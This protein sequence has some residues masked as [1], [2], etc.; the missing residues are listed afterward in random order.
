MNFLFWN[1]NKNKNC[2]SIIRDMIYTEDIDILMIAE[3]PLYTSEDELLANF[4]TILK[5]YT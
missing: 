5:I 4:L 3:Y 2:F 1:I